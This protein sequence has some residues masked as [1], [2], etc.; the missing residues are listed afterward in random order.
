MDTKAN[1]SKV[2]CSSFEIITSHQCVA[3]DLGWEDAAAR[4]KRNGYVHSDWNQFRQ[5]YLAL[6][7]RLRG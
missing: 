3:K 5:W 2:R 7:E 6:Y 1:P 4:L